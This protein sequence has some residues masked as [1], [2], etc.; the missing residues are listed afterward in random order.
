[1]A[2]RAS[3]SALGAGIAWAWAWAWAWAS[4]RH[5]EST[6]VLM[7]RLGGARIACRSNEV[8]AAVPTE[9]GST[10]SKDFRRDLRGLRRSDGFF[11]SNRPARPGARS[12]GVLVQVWHRLDVGADDFAVVGGW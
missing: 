1:V 3:R 10:R 6:D 5:P 11:E 2:R 7:G 8:P 12:R 4:S 9:P